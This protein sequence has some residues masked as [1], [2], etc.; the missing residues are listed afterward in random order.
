MQIFLLLI[1]LAMMSPVFGG[2]NHTDRLSLLAIKAQLQD[3]L[4]VLNSWNASQQFCQWPGVTCS[5]RHRRVTVLDLHSYKLKGKL[6]PHVG[7]LSFLRMLSLSGNS[8]S[9]HIPP[10]IGHLFRLRELYLN[11][12]SFSGEIPHNISHCSSLQYLRLSEN[13]LSGKLP[14]DIGFISTS[15]KCLIWLPTT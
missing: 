13:N 6:S 7:N 9:H 1:A 11:N 15:L 3:P 14:K 8:F 2:N 4:G 10:Q 5:P 12:N